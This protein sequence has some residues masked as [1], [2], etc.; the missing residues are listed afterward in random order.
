MEKEKNENIESHKYIGFHNHKEVISVY[1]KDKLY[2]EKKC[3]ELLLNYFHNVQ[4]NVTR[5]PLDYYN[6]EV[7]YVGVKIEKQEPNPK[8]LEF[9]FNQEEPLLVELNK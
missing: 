6:G 1:G 4:D 2:A 8:Q 9:N 3:K 5:L 7:A